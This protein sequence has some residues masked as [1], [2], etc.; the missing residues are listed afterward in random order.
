[1]GSTP[2]PRSPMGRYFFKQMRT[3]I[4]KR[5]S[6]T[7]PREPGVSAALRKSGTDGL[8]VRASHLSQREAIGG[9]RSPPTEAAQRTPPTNLLRWLGGARLSGMGALPTLNRYPIK[10]SNAGIKPFEF[11]KSGP[12]DPGI[13]MG[14]VAPGALRGESLG[15]SGLGRN[16]GKSRSRQVEYAPAVEK[17]VKMIRKCPEAPEVRSARR[18]WMGERYSARSRRAASSAIG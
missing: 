16:A 9:K 12:R 5:L 3:K 4:R 17:V 10:M 7:L 13:V 2:L 6:G 1:M 8:H 11:F 14:A 18:R 15:P